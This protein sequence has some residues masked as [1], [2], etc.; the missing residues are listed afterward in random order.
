[1]VMQGNQGVMAGR[2]REIRKNGSGGFCGQEELQSCLGSERATE[3]R[4][5]S[6]I[7]I[8]LEKI[9]KEKIEE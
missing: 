6:P 8:F 2:G 4:S 9:E 7:E 3:R 5:N 1:M